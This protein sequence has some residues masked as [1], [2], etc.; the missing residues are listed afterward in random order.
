MQTLYSHA[1]GLDVHK[2]TIVACLKIAGRPDHV[3]TFGTMTDDLLALFDWLARNK[4]AHVAMESTGV[5]WKPV[6][7]ILKGANGSCGWSTRGTSSKC[8]VQERHE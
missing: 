6:W 4:V 3:R 1:A 7:N 2:T 8:R 5:L